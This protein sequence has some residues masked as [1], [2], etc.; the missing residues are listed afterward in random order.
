MIGAAMGGCGED[1]QQALPSG[2][3]RPATAATTST[4]NVVQAGISLDPNL[5]S[6]TGTPTPTDM[7]QLIAL[8]AKV[9]Y[10]VI[11]PTELPGGY[12]LEADLMGS[13]SANKKDPVGYYSFRYSDPGKQNRTLA[14]N[15]SHA[16]SK[17]L[18]GY[19]LT[20]TEINGTSY[21][22]YWHKTL[23]YLPAGEPVRT[24]A[25]GD[26]ET[27]VV[28]WK[29]QFTDPA[30]N[31]QELWYSIST[32]TWTGHGW[33]DIMAILNSLKPLSAVGS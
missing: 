15:Q 7:K 29:S 14:F 32:G 33:G 18:S 4:P 22:V 11:V 16:N 31:P 8:Q 17:P 26:A 28:V 23:E 19:Y 21:E 25:V 30:G 9:P 6:V 1:D 10:Q 2:R 24:V 3:T 27:F 20:E 13:S 5:Q 12:V